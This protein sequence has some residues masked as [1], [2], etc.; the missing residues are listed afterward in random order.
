VISKLRQITVISLVFMTIEFL[1]GYYAHSIAIFADAFH[2]LS[3]VSAYVISLYAVH[4]SYQP[5]P[6]ALTFGFQKVQPLGALINVA[7]IWVVTLELF[8]EATL[9]I[10]HYAVVEDPL[11]MLG[12]SVFGLLCNLY[13]MR[14]LHNDEHA[15][16]HQGCSHSHHAHPHPVE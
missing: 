9:R 12:T 3:D 4:K 14:V 15:G 6:K 13:I 2:L 11:I 10:F 16:G 7:I 1:G 5:S 8:L